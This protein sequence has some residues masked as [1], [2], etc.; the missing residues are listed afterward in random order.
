MSNIPTR[1]GPY[2]ILAPLGTGGM[3]EVY[4]ARD[5]RLDREVAL[6]IVPTEL[7]TA[8]FATEAK[9]VAALTHPNIVNVFD[10]GS[11][12]GLSYM[13]MELLEGESLRSLL[14]TGPLP[15]KQAAKIAA[16]ISDALRYAHAKGIIHRDLKPE[17][18]LITR[19]GMT[20]VLDFGLARVTPRA[21]TSPD[22]DVT[23]TQPGSVVGTIGYMSPEQ[24]RGEAI[25][26]ETDIFSLGCVLYE[27]LG[28]VRPFER[29]SSGEVIAA[30][31]RDSPRDLRAIRPDVPEPFARIVEHCLEKDPGQRFDTM[32]DFAFALDSATQQASGETTTARRRAA[33]PPRSTLIARGAALLIVAVI[34]IVLG[35]LA[36]TRPAT[37]P[38]GRPISSLA[39]LPF[40]NASNDRNN[41]YLSDGL[42][43]AIINDLSPISGLR[44]MSRGSVF[45]YK[46][47]SIDPRKVALDLGVDAV[48]SG[49]V[50]QRADVLTVSVEL[51]DSR[52]G[53][54]IW[55]ERYERPI[56]QM[57]N[58]ERELASNISDKLKMRLTSADQVRMQRTHDVDPEAYRLYLQGRYEW[59]KR[60]PDGLRKGI[61]FFRHSIDIDP[62]YA[63]S[64]AGLADS[65]LLLGNYEVLRPA[66]A[67]PIARE[68]AMKALA[69]DDSLADAHASLGLIKHE[70]EWNW[71]TAEVEF[72]RAIA[73]NPNH[74]LAHEW[75][76][77]ALLYRSRFAEGL[78]ELRRAEELDPLSIVAKADVAQAYWITGQ[79]DQAIAQ[80][81]KTIEMEPRF[82]LAHWFL[83]LSYAGE[84]EFQKAAKSLETAVSLGGSPAARGSLGYVYARM[85]RRA[86]ALRILRDLR[87]ESTTRYISPAPFAEIYI[88]LGDMDHAYEEVERA[89]TERTS[90]MTV[91]NVAPM[92]EPLRRDPRYAA[93]KRRVGLP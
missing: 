91:L 8:R 16:A 43:E 34:I 82:W 77:Q 26:P 22:S 92:V 65:Y 53:H 33:R 45:V 47:K 93:V 67:M 74:V 62:A 63:P 72:K 19:E 10:V 38:P 17:N 5:T 21:E 52:D 7:A 54:Q 13:A 89:F 20:K 59:N 88:G 31:L 81:A 39:I 66:E 41:D 73:L 2:E 12:Q 58:L 90:L 78:S 4:R 70:Y 44:V 51:V 11:D 35:R 50:A 83:G 29:K 9:A 24:V 64:Y 40:V 69:I 79:Y 37:P 36:A 14:A 25:G 28:G 68:A 46:S 3:G 48:V 23:L 55:G 32:A 71:P 75:Y 27:M 84:G 42:T 56:A 30:I 80:S 15:W 60:T 57:T 49:R 18:I 61:E 76:G 86:D 6:K 1:L 85:G 87:K